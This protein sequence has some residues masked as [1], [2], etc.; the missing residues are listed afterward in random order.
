MKRFFL[1]LVIA[2]L[3]IPT[4]EAQF[5]FG[6]YGNSSY[7]SSKQSAS[8]TFKNLSDYTMTLRIIRATGG[9]YTSIILGPHSSRV[10]SFSNSSNF[11][12]KIKATSS[13]GRTS[14]HDGGKF[15]VTCTD[16]KWSEGEMS[17]RMAS[18]GSG[19]GPTIS[20]KQ[21]ESDY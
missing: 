13:F 14:Y 9:C 7:F 15:S 11:K 5:N 12:L 8:I 1:A 2:L 6:S 21:F 19:L 3:A 17:F 20:A 16:T 4:I 10:V 18:N